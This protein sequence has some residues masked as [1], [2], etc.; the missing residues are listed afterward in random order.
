MY[1]LGHLN[2][3]NWIEHFHPATYRLPESEK[4][5][6]CLVA[7]VPRGN[8]EIFLRLVEA[9]TP[10]YYLLYVLHTPRGEGLPGRYQSPAVGV[11]E[12]RHFV[13]TFK[14][15][16][17][18]DARFNFWAHSSVDNATVVWDRHNQI[19]AYGPLADFVFELKGLGFSEG[20]VEVPGPHEHYY[21]E[22]FD[23][24]AALV[25]KTFDWVHSP[26]KRE[27]EQ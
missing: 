14:Q 7:G 9:L 2:G 12:L 27:D 3:D 5:R 18:S 22:E 11:V 26:L 20:K 13:T 25:L 1:K 17:A 6:Q 16:L 23:V 24:H 15:Y 8:P 19:F 21:R 4:V 10:P